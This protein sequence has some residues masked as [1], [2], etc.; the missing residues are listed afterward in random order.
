MR[1]HYDDVSR[2]PLMVG[3]LSLFSSGATIASFLSKTNPKK[4]MKMYHFQIHAAVHI[5]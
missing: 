2:P 4:Y 5:I 1:W 3:G